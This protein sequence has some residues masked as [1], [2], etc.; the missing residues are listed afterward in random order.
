MYMYHTVFSNDTKSSAYETNL[1]SFERNY[2]TTECNHLEKKYEL[3]LCPNGKTMVLVYRYM[4]K[5]VLEV[6]YHIILRLSNSPGAY[7]FP[8]SMRVNFWQHI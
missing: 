3:P 8:V 4:Q 7:V 5:P 6:A 2:A 1:K